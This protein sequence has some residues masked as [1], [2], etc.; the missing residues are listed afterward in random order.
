MHRGRFFHERREAMVKRWS[1]LTLSCAPNLRFRV[2]FLFERYVL[3]EFRLKI[4][5]ICHAMKMART[6]VE[7]LHADFN[8]ST[9]DVVHFSSG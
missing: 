6:A 4:T 9:Y 5:V 2:M 3:A 8:S 7:R 1:A